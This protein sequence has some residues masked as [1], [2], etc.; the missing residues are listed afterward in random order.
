[1][2]IENLKGF[3]KSEIP[4]SPGAFFYCCNT[5]RLKDGKFRHQFIKKCSCVGT[6]DLEESQRLG[7]GLKCA[8]L[9]FISF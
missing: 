4:F 7:E 5:K 3:G 6:N 2:S 8:F 9:A 1:M